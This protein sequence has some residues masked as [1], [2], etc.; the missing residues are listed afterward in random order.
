MTERID[1]STAAGFLSERQDFLHVYAAPS[2]AGEG[3]DVV[4]R[5][6]GTYTER[7]DAE[8]AVEG[9][10]DWIAGLEDVAGDKRVWW[11]GPPFEVDSKPRSLRIVTGENQGYQDNQRR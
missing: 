1:T 5:I 3:F 4:L 2:V 7:A 11:D 8:E 9:I 6:D 10:R